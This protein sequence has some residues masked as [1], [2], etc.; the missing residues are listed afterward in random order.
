MWSGRLSRRWKRRTFL[1]TTL[2]DKL[3]SVPARK[4][5]AFTVEDGWWKETHKLIKIPY[6]CY[7]F[8]HVLSC[9][10]LQ[11][12]LF[13]V[14]SASQKMNE[15]KHELFEKAGIGIPHEDIESNDVTI[16]G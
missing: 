7:K 5:T 1:I 15:F 8:T 3:W 2:W 13:D 9:F 4:D 14:G 10:Y 6:S 16:L 12:V 11:I